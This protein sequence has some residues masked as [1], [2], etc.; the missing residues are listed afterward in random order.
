MLR[1][2]LCYCLIVDYVLLLLGLLVC[3]GVYCWCCGC[4]LMWCLVLVAVCLWLV[5]LKL[6]TCGCLVLCLYS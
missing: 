5:L 1:G 2:A 3:L 4:S 6:F